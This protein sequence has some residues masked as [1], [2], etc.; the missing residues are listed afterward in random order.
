MSDG[1]VYVDDNGKQT[2][3]AGSIAVTAFPANG[4]NGNGND[5]TFDN[6]SGLA[7]NYSTPVEDG[8]SKLDIA[9]SHHFTITLEGFTQYLTPQKTFSKF[10]PVKSISLVHTSYENM[11]I[12]LAIFGDFPLLNRKKLS[13]ISLTCFDLD[14]NKLEKELLEWEAMCFPKNKFV[15]YMEDIVRE[16]VY[17]GYNV[18]GQ[19][20]IERRMFVIPA[21]GVSVSRDYSANDAKLVNFSLIAVGNGTDSAR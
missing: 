12:P 11:T 3:F 15:A 9:Q 18:K 17:R 1:I 8:I 5:L 2:T 10:L 13:S 20:T 6:L 16:M 19:Q 21:G 4:L 14:N 7:S